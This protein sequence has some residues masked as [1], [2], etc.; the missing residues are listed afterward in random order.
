[1]E[2]RG[3]CAHG[4]IKMSEHNGMQINKKAWEVLPYLKISIGKEFRMVC[5]SHI[6]MY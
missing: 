3:R 1:M 2:L 5:D 6:S 4:V